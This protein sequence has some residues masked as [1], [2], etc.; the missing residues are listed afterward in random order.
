MKKLIYTFA[1]VLILHCTLKIDNCSAQ[2]VQMSSGMGNA[3]VPALA[4]SGNNIFAGAYEVTFDGSQF[5]SGFYFYR[6]EVADKT[7]NAGKIYRTVK[8]MVLIK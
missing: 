1:F 8:K 5:P 7:L 3:S 4:Y 6:I 2:W